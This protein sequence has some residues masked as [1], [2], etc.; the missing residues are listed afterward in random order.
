MVNPSF[1][2]YCKY[3]VMLIL[4]GGGGIAL[5][6]LYCHSSAPHSSVFSRKLWF[7]HSDSKQFASSNLCVEL[8]LAASVVLSGRVV[9]ENSR[10]S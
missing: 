2:I 3:G 7:V 1:N 4:T 5:V 6:L 8:A 10:S 9:S